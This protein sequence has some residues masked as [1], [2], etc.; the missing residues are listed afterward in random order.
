MSTK[1]YPA[2]PVLAVAKGGT[3]ATIPKRGPIP[4]FD[5]WWEKNQGKYTA[6][7]LHMSEYHIVLWAWTE[8]W[9]AALIEASSTDAA[10]ANLVISTPTCQHKSTRN[11]AEGDIL[12]RCIHCGAGKNVMGDWCDGTEPP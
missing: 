7:A 4:T 10:R 5:E 8:A 6:D 11:V 9:T 2:P 12:F 1:N 3:G